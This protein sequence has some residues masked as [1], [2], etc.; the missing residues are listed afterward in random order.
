MRRR[1]LVIAFGGVALAPQIA[2]AQQG[3]KVSRIGILSLAGNTSTKVLDA[4]R[5]GLRN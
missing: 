2:T 1:D 5:R 3:K 4:F